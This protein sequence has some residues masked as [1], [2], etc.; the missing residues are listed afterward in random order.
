[1]VN[2]FFDRSQDPT[3][4]TN[5]L[6]MGAPSDRGILHK[7]NSNGNGSSRKNKG[8]MSNTAAATTAAAPTTT[9]ASARVG[10]KAS[11]SFKK[12]LRRTHNNKNSSN[13]SKSKHQKNERT[14]RGSDSSPGA[15]QPTSTAASSPSSLAATR[16]QRASAKKGKRGGLLSSILSNKSNKNSSSN[17][18]QQQQQQDD[19]LPVISLSHS[20]AGTAHTTSPYHSLDNPGSGVTQL[21]HN[22]SANGGIAFVSAIDLSNK[23]KD[24]FQWQDEMEEQEK[25]SLIQKKQ[26]IKERDGFCRR[27]DSYD[28]QVIYVEGKAAYELGNYLGGGVAGVVYEGH[29]L[30][31]IEEYPVR[32]GAYDRTN[33][34]LQQHPKVVNTA[35]HE[36]PDDD[37]M[38]VESFLCMPSKV[39]AAGVIENTTIVSTASFDNRDTSFLTMDSQSLTTLGGET[40]SLILGNNNNYYSPPPTQ[41]QQ[42]QQ[43]QEHIEEIALE[44]TRS[45]ANMVII[46][47]VDAPSRSKH[48]A[49]AVSMNV[50]ES[51]FQSDASFTGGGMMEETVAIKILNPVGFRTL[52]ASATQTAVVAREGEV[53]EPNVVQGLQPM[54]ERHVWWLV[55]PSSRNLRTLQR[56]NVDKGPRTVEVDRGS[57]EKGLRISLIAAYKDPE[58]KQLRELPLTRC[59]EIWG[60]VPFGASDAEFKQIMSA[61]DR[62]NQG[63][64]PPPIP[65]FLNGV[66]GRIGTGNTSGTASIRSDSF[67]Y[68]ADGTSL[69]S[70]APMH[71]KRT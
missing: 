23:R 14:R 39:D 30:Q 66:S 33:S 58:T 60:H 9:T 13:D 6:G 43:Q 28:G 34:T 44:A 40:N 25:R 10:S 67:S 35:E 70:P 53:L 29:R 56:Y 18:Q 26:L 20:T 38:T 64:P 22:G 45:N 55:N 15:E 63:Q 1:M 54:E 41:T 21:I 49:K 59:I 19:S 4:S 32:S 12:F 16:A 46:D 7:N 27:V 31:P 8:K 17:I 50:A 61:I 36:Q 11:S 3:S 48:F 62:V 51:D 24:L 57:P 71:S 5:V 37:Q 2:I 69:G 52:A 65:K 42:R 47:K 68:N